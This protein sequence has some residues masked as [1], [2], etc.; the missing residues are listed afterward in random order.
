MVYEQAPLPYKSLEP[1]YDDRTL[2]V[3]YNK[4]HK[5]YI[6][7][8]NAAL[9]EVGMEDKALEY[10]L[11]HLDEVPEAKRQFIANNGGG[12][13]NHSFFW[14]CM[15]PESERGEMSPELRAA[16][17]RDFGDFKTFMTGF[18]DAA[19]TQFG[20]GWA[21]LVIDP[22]TK[23]LSIMKT[24]NQA[25]PINEGKFKPLLTIDVWEHAYYLLHMSNR[26]GWI[27][28]FGHNLVNWNFVNAEFAKFQ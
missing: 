9:K 28:T 5:A 7:K 10:V 1:H 8:V 11:G 13:W 24:L 20:S 22:A 26:P 16:I 3:H 23:K 6:D 21:W 17:E 4:H 2:D 19:A 18:A 14:K 12:A 27:K 15:A 25:T